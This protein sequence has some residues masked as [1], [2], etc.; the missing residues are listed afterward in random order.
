[1]HTKL[2]TEKFDFKNINFIGIGGGGGNIL[3]KLITRITPKLETIYINT[4][5]HSFSK[6]IAKHKIHYNTDTFESIW[7]NFQIQLHTNTNSGHIDN[8]SEQSNSRQECI[9]ITCLGGHAG[10][11]ISKQLARSY[12]TM[13]LLVH[14]FATLPFNFEGIERKVIAETTIGSLRMCCKTLKTFDNNNSISLL[15]ENVSFYDLLDFTDQE[16]IKSIISKGFYSIP[17]PQP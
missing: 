17:Q 4:D 6:S 5:E 16:L 8:K 12:K 10:S 9:I 2:M 3:N 11:N 7:N 13:G 15:G 1:M 14:I